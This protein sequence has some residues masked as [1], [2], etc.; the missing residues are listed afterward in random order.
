MVSW[1]EEPGRREGRW[2]HNTRAGGVDE[3]GFKR[4]WVGEARL[5]RD[6]EVLSGREQR[7]R[8]QPN[9]YSP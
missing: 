6:E 5:R 4:W 8:K 9:P 1:A 2:G 3:A 7:G